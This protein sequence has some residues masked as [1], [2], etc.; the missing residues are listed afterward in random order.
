M[1]AQEN[2]SAMT[3]ENTRESKEFVQNFSTRC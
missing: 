3:R 2:D 1:K